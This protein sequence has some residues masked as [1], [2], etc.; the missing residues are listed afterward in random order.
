[1]VVVVVA[2]IRDAGKSIHIE[3]QKKEQNSAGGTVV[4]LLVKLYFRLMC[5]SKLTCCRKNTIIIIDRTLLLLYRS[6]TR[7]G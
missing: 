2:R 6:G 4:P 7:P 5:Q 1:M 3:S